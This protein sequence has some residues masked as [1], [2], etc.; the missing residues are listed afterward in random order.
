V[1]CNPA[2]ALPSRVGERQVVAVTRAQPLTIPIADAVYV[3]D[4][5]AAAPA[6]QQ[7][8]SRHPPRLGRRDARRK[9]EVT[10]VAVTPAVIA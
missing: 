3:D 7:R 8:L 1:L 10:A 6:A 4:A 5:A 9:P 2:C